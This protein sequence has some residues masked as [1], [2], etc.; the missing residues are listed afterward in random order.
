MKEM[1][2]KLGALDDVAIEPIAPE[3]INSFHRGLDLVAYGRQYL[4]IS[5]AGLWRIFATTSKSR[6]RTVT[7]S[8]SLLRRAKSWDGAILNDIDSRRMSI[9]ERSILRSFLD[10]EI[11]VSVFGS[12]RR[13]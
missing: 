7:R 1:E 9:L 11:V 3:H 13:P 6:Y 8:S 10:S 12:F 2:H 5:D 4:D